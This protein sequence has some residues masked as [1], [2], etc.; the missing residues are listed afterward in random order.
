LSPSREILERWILGEFEVLYTLDT[1]VE[2]IR[3]CREIGISSEDVRA[4]LTDFAALGILV[5]VSSFHERIYPTDPD[6]IAF[7]LCATNGDATHLVT[8][9]S[10]FDPVRI[11]YSF[12]VC[13][14]LEFL[15]EL[16]KAEPN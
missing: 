6:D 3:K 10:D 11:A 13:A 12:T 2:Y 1:V 15:R 9:D 16:R 4:L 8:Y 14:P 5:T 7:L